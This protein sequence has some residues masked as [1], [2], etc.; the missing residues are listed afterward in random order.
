MDVDTIV[1][2][3][4]KIAI[5][6]I[7]VLKSLCKNSMILDNTGIII[8]SINNKTTRTAV[9]DQ[10]L[11]HVLRY[12][13]QIDENDES[14]FMDESFQQSLGQKQ[15]VGM[16]IGEL[17]AIWNKLNDEN[18]NRIFDYM[19]VLCFYSQNYFLLLENQN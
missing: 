5:D 4:N 15:G 9:I 19:K 16:I 13:P 1:D 10:F 14:F 12:K 6:F 8:E 3:F 2:D 7:N 17:K 11:I 18:R